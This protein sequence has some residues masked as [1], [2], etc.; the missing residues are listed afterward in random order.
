MDDPVLAALEKDCQLLLVIEVKSTAVSINHLQLVCLL[1]QLSKTHQVVYLAL[2]DVD[3]SKTALLLS[4]KVDEE[5]K[6]LSCE[7]VS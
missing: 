5:P 3:F 6:A 7:V 4:N 1:Y 2:A